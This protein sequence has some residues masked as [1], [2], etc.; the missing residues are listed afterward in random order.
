MKEGEGSATAPSMSSGKKPA[1]RLGLLVWG[2]YCLCALGWQVSAG[3]WRSDFGGHSDEA[4][5][6]VTG[7][8]VRDYLAGGFVD[9]WHPMR[10]AEAYYERFPKVA[11]GHYPPAFY[12][13]EALI[14][15]PWRAPG[16][17]L[18]LMAALAATLG[19]QTWRMGRERMGGEIGPLLL[20]LLVIWL[21]LVRTYTAIVMSDLLLAILILEATRTFGRFLESDHRRDA[22]GFGFL[23]AAAILTKGSGLLLALVPPLAILLSGRWRVLTSPRLWLAPIPVLALALPWML[24]TRHIT[25][26]G[27]SGVA[28]TEYLPTA[29]RYYSIG[30]ARE[31]GGVTVLLLVVAAV[32][33]LRRRWGKADRIGTGEAAWWALAGGLLLFY[34]AIPSG[35]DARYLLP[36][37]PVVLLI[38]A[39]RGARLGARW[40]GLGRWVAPAVLGVLVVVLAHRPVAKRYTGAA[41]AVEVAVSVAVSDASRA[42][43]TLLVI[44]NASGEGAITAA[45]AFRDDGE[46]TVK[47][48]SKV[49][50]QSDW[51]GRHYEPRFSSREEFRALLDAE[52]IDVLIIERLPESRS[53]IPEHWAESVR[54]LE[55]GETGDGL[56]LSKSVRSERKSGQTSQFQLY[57]VTPQRSEGEIRRN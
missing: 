55:S 29:V 10:Y 22:W 43:L 53:G 40:S 12:L 57:R 25:A 49:L 26:E 45:A 27:M 56:V 19:W 48:A 51:L 34:G 18:V 39:E 46:L 52:R 36:A 44:S 21:P 30:M 13:L 6:V 28:L 32:D 50:A 7:L 5:H 2:A 16:A 37:V 1:W 35:L 31:F 33:L 24:A 14:F 23:A 15:L 3:A 9:Q 47:R 8:M 20:G 17:A 4:A 54:Y 11:I 42:P 38:V 41:D